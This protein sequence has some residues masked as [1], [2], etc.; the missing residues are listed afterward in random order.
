[1]REV[2]PQEPAPTSAT[3]LISLPQIVTQQ[4]GDETFVRVERPVAGSPSTPTGTRTAPTKDD[5][6]PLS[7]LPDLTDGSLLPGQSP[8][9]APLTS[10]SDMGPEPGDWKEAPEVDAPDAEGGTAQEP[11]GGVK[12]P[13]PKK[14]KAKRKT[15]RPSAGNGGAKPIRTRTPALRNPDGTP[16]RQNPGYFDALPG[17]ARPGVPDFVIEKFRVPP[18]LLPIYQAA[19]HPVRHP[20]GGPR[21]D[22][23]DRDRLRPQ[24]ERL[25]RR[26]AR[27][28]AVHAGH[29]EDVRH[30]RQPRRQ[31]RPVQP[32]RRDLLRRA[33]PQGRRRDQDDPRRR[34]FAYNHADWYVD[35]VL[36]RAQ[37]HR[38][39]TRPTSSAR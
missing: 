24:P 16:T 30:R 12:A 25:V 5:G 18:F 17:P 36:M 33:L 7:S 3:E 8:A 23:R 21:G 6:K 4:V 13:K 2:L 9:A 31:A 10:L 35:S 29:L 34:I 20:L 32:G 11:T 15:P 38:R 37:A 19:G 26:R 28:D 22:Q 27:L 14:K 1:M 39:R